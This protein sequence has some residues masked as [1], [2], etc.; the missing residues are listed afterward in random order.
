MLMTKYKFWLLSCLK[1]GMLFFM[2]EGWKLRLKSRE[3]NAHT[4]A[5]SELRF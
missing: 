4:F 2:H 3:D 5:V 1:G